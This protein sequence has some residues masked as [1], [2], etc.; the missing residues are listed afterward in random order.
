MN[1]S[2][3]LCVFL[4]AWKGIIL[5]LGWSW[6]NWQNGLFNPRNEATF[7]IKSIGGI[8]GKYVD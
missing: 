3:S 5:N 1:I 7:K 2:I 6:T 8:L 4:D